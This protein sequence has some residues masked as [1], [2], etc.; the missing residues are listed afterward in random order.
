MRQ[1][2][3]IAKNNNGILS[4]HKKEAATLRR[5][6][7]KLERNLLGI[8]DMEHLPGAMFVIDIMCEANAIAE[9]R[10]LGIP[11]I[12]IVDTNCDPDEIDYIIPGNDD[13]IRAVKLISAAMADGVI[14]GRQGEQTA[15][16][17]KQEETKEE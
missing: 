11:V 2:Q 15:D 13:A 7:D 8:A 4:I 5:E 1:L 12:A 16:T 3:V 10:R 17:E 14:E 9:A 6:L